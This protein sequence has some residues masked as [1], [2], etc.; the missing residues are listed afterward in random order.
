MVR[1][2]ELVGARD[3]HVTALKFKGLKV[4]VDQLDDQ[5]DQYGWSIVGE[6]GLGEDSGEEPIHLTPYK[7]CF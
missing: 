1:R 6:A 3:H 5:K 4:E 2:S 7:P